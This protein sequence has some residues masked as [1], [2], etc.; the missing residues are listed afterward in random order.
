M[1]LN[2]KN[3]SD[4][5]P[6][7]MDGDMCICTVASTA[8]KSIKSL[9]FNYGYYNSST[10][11]VPIDSPELYGFLSPKYNFEKLIWKVFPEASIK[12][13]SSYDKWQQFTSD[14]YIAIKLFKKEPK[15]YFVVLVPRNK[16][17]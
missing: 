6:R 12:R 11:K 3:A 9:Q 8:D 15:E 17:A 2:H 10:L 4:T 13:F 7:L 16:L 5:A 14:E 1:W